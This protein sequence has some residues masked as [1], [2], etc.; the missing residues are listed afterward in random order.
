MID[1]YGLW[2]GPLHDA[3]LISSME[4]CIGSKLSPMDTSYSTYIYNHVHNSE[5]ISSAYLFTGTKFPCHKIKYIHVWGCPVYVL[6][7]M[8]Q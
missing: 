3:S 7:C 5:D 8:L 2:N 1:P 6:D 4:N